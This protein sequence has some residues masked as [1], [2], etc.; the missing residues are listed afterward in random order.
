MLALQ[1]IRVKYFALVNFLVVTYNVTITEY[2]SC[3]FVEME[4]ERSEVLKKKVGALAY[5]Q[6]DKRC[7]ATKRYG[8]GKNT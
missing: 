4:I 8:E 3:Y 6:P 2:C 5:H 7:G 1:R